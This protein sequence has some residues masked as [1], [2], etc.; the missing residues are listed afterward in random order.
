MDLDEA[1]RTYREAREL[2]TLVSDEWERTYN[3]ATSQAEICQRDDMTG[4]IFPIVIIRP[5]CPY[6]DGQLVEKSL[7]Y[8]RALMMVIDEAFAKIRRLEAQER[9]PQPP[10]QTK[11]KD[12]AAECAM[13]CGKQDF[14]R[15]LMQCHDLA[16]AGDDERVNTRVRHILNIRSRAELNTD[17][18]AAARWKRL[19]R[20]YYAWKDGR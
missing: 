14:R 8:F 10:Q 16:D 7:T 17:H 6:H 1:K 15:Y 3:P 2:L 19:R 4:E 9:P 5:D 18:Q 20:D 12:L 11:K 13:L